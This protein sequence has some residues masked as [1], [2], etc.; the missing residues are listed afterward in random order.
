VRCRPEHHR[1]A[2]ARLQCALLG[3]DDENAG[4]E[5]AGLEID[6]QNEPSRDV[7]RNQVDRRRI[8]DTVYASYRKKAL[9]CLSVC[10]F[11]NS[12]KSYGQI[13]LKVEE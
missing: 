9:A 12:S 4:S 5:N 1:I 7:C 6:G 3:G 10:Q 11:V 2:A 13:F 8:F